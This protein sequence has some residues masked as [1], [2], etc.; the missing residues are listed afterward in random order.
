[1]LR[2]CSRRRC[3]SLAAVRSELV[4][5]HAREENR[6]TETMIGGAAP[7]SLDSYGQSRM[8]LKGGKRNILL[9]FVGVPDL[10]LFI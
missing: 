3:V 2:P 4:V 6:D 8:P 7:A 5:T 10:A 9:N 1:M